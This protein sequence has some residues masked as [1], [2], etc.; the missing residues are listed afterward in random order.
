MKRFRVA[1][2]QGYTIIELLVII[3]VITVLASIVWVSYSAV[4]NN[5]KDSAVQSDLR[6]IADKVEDFR[7]GSLTNVYP[8]A[9]QAELEALVKVTKDAYIQNNDA[10][11][12]SYCRNDTDFTILGRS[13]SRNAF[14]FSSKTG[15][16]EVTFTGNLA[17][18]CALGG[19]SSSDSGY[20]AI[21]LLK[22]NLN[23]QGYGWQSWIN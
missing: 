19:I 11:G 1:H 10:G 5:T 7:L 8:A 9:T 22:G 20:G 17:A 3:V 14:I 23:A 16:K 6:N 21:W 13:A 2:N 15:L 18:Q 12:M 4:Q